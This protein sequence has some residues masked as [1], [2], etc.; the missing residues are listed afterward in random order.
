MMSATEML[1]LLKML[2]YFAGYSGGKEF[3]TTINNLRNRKGERGGSGIRNYRE[4]S[5][6][7]VLYSERGRVDHDLINYLLRK[8]AITYNKNTTNGSRNAIIHSH[9]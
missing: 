2:S 6:G 5:K 1:P 9:Q 7:G 8:G 3:L 4:Q